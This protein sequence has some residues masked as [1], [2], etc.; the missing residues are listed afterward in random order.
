MTRMTRRGALR[1]FALTASSG[2]ALAAGTATAQEDPIT[3][4]Y[5]VAR[6]GANATGAGITTSPTYELW[7][8]GVN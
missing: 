4:G 2:L 8:H 6:T 5:A 3:V 1:I 7:V